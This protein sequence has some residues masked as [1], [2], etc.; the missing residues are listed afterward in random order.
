MTDYT[1]ITELPGCKASREQLARLYQRYHF[2]YQFCRSKDILEVACGG[3]IGLG[4]LAKSAK[5]IIGGDI[6]E[7]ILEILKKTYKNKGNIRIV[8]FCAEH[9]PFTDKSFDTV[10]LYEA[11]YYVRRPDKFVQEA[12]RVLRNNG[13]LIVCSVNKD[14]KDFNP[15]PM[16]EKYFS[17]PELYSLLHQVF[18]EIELFGAFPVSGAGAKDAL[19]SMIK[20]MAVG[21]HLMPKTMKGKELFKRFFFGEL[22][23]L[24]LELS[25]GVVEYSQPTPIRHDIPSSDYKILFALASI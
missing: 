24:P 16:S 23:P 8:R 21:L 6:D 15:S 5:R 1:T 18:P 12:A 13:K 20:R 4:Y 3:G 10:L 11:I 25:G 2:A 7:K 14:W 22:I 9:I 19:T 17:V